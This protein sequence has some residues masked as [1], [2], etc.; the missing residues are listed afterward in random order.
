MSHI[1]PNG[2]KHELL[3]DFL[4]IGAGKSGTTSLDNYLK[5]HPQI[6]IPSMKEPNFFGYERVNRSDLEKDPQELKHYTKSVTDLPG[7]LSLFA[8]ARPDHVKG[9]TSNTY[10]YHQDAPE[11]IHYYHPSIKLIAILRQPAERLWSR[12][13]HLSRDGRLPTRNFED[14]LDKNSIW[15]RRNDLIPEGF[16]CKYLLRY[17]KIFPRDQIRIYLFEEFNRA[18][19]EVL[20]NIFEFLGVDTAFG[21]D[22]SVKYN[23]SGII[24]NKK[25]DRI[26][27]TEGLL[28]KTAKSVLGSHYSKLKD[29]T[30]VQSWI[31]SL[32]RKNLKKPKLN[33]RIKSVLTHEVY[34]EDIRQLQRLIG[35]DLS[36]WMKAEPNSSNE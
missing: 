17:F 27:G 8:G 25:F 14:C 21:P 31:T 12:Y 9:E 1:S 24:K 5:Q 29:S 33:P 2:K 10:L 20:A 16:Y 15:W 28:Q 3:P 36:H 22:L 13:L 11:R 4:I 34:G 26:I 7:Y 32:R 19:L 6:F 35:R 23:E 30:V 18:P